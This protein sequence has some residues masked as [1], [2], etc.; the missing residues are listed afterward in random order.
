MK[1]ISS[2]RRSISYGI[3]DVDPFGLWRNEPCAILAA[4][5][6]GFRLKQVGELPVYSFGSDAW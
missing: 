2:N 5:G 6:R 1:A 3:R 4:M